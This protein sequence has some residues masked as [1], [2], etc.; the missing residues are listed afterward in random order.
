MTAIY[1][2]KF[3]LINAKELSENIP[4]KVKLVRW[5]VA[6]V[7]EKDSELDALRGKFKD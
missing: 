1:A 5:L 3:L 4:Q 7:M 6:K 2:I